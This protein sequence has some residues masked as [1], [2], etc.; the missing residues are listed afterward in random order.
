MRESWVVRGAI[1]RPVFGD[2]EERWDEC[3]PVSHC[4]D[5][6]RLASLQLPPVLLVSAENELQEV[7]GA[8]TVILPFLQAG[9][10]DA[11]HVIIAGTGHFSSVLWIGRHFARA[12]RATVGEIVQFAR[13]VTA[14]SVT[15]SPPSEVDI[16]HATLR[17]ADLACSPPIELWDWY[18]HLFLWS[19]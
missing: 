12:E 11:Q 3:F 17:H 4:R 5:A 7:R 2:D 15:G 9:G 14:S 6:N 8:D 1:M 18:L 13:R 19:L 16:G 10:V